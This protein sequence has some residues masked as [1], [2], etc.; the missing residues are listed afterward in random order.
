MDESDCTRD[1]FVG[2][3]TGVEECD[4]QDSENIVVQISAGS[5]SKEIL[6]NN[7]EE[8]VMEVDGC[9][10]IIPDQS[11]N[12]F[13]ESINVMGNG[14][15]SGDELTISLVIEIGNEVNTC[16]LSFTRQ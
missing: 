14:D 15:L 16:E 13:G 1:D 2:T 11:F 9:D 5:N 8:F 10:L 4:G 6:F 3:W 12:L 7:E